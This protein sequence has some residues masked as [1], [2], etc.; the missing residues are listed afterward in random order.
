[1]T[2]ENISHTAEPKPEPAPAPVAEAAPVP[3]PTATPVPEPEPE[4]VSQD[5]PVDLDPWAAPPEPAAPKD[6]RV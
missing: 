2:T 4:P 3:E 6:R 1:M 5:A